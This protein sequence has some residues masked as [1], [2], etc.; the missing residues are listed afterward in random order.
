VKLKR[1]RI[2][3]DAPH[4]KFKDIRARAESFREKYVSPVDL[5]PVPIIDIVELKF[6]IMPILKK[7]L[8]KEIDID[9]FLTKD[10]KNIV[11]D[12][13]V[14]ND[15]RQLNRLRFTYSHEIGHL[16]LHE[17]EI[18]QCDFR[19]Q[20]DWIHFHEDFL[21]DDLDWFEQQ[22]REFA[23][24]LLVPKDI[25]ISELLSNREKI[26]KFERLVDSE[27]VLIEGISGIICGRFGVSYQVIQKRIRRENI[28]DTIKASLKK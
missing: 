11:I 19:T 8:L 25:L 10:L 27:E 4:L 7:G 21:R 6:G 1:Q 5:V 24:R 2:F 16:I 15:D 20:E 26:I 28:W 12:E 23:G 22:A 3:L 18:K 13:D 14:F 9:G 17:N